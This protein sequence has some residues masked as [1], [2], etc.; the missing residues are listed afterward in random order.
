[1]KK[2][3]KIIFYPQ[4][5]R[6]LLECLP[7]INLLGEDDR[8][9]TNILIENETFMKKRNY[10]SSV[11]Y[12][13]SEKIKI[14]SKT[15]DIKLGSTLINFLECLFYKVFKKRANYLLNTLPLILI[16]F[17]LDTLDFLFA[18]ISAWFFYVINKPDILLIVRDRN[19][20]FQTSLIKSLKKKNKKVV[21]I[22]WGFFNINFLLRSRILSPRNIMGLKSNNYFHKL[23]ERKSPN[24]IFKYNNFKYSYYKIGRYLAAIFC[25]ICP[26]NPWVYGSDSSLC[27]VDNKETKLEL[28]KNNVKENK[29]IVCGNH[30]YDEIKKKKIKKNKIRQFLVRKYNLQNRIIVLAMPHVIEHNLICPKAYRKK[31]LQVKDILL[32]N[33]NK[34]ILLSVHPRAQKSDYEFLID[35]RTY[36]LEESLRNIIVGVDYLVCHWSGVTFWGPLVAK[37]TMVLDIF[38][39]PFVGV[40]YL[41]KKVMVVKNL[42]DLN[43]KIS[44]F[45]NMRGK[46]VPYEK[47]SV[48]KF[49]RNLFRLN[50]GYF[51][52]N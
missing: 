37:P 35:T 36:F 15:I 46:N 33:N 47:F 17:I 19:L 3:I 41:S 9:E 29:I 30:I 48:T 31:M 11:P 4:G 10:D 26:S 25:G 40:N 21:I 13:V 16:F 24:H 52:K 2:K 6:Y 14:I 39:L 44:Y 12:Q 34:S 38:S 49:K 43:K 50:N 45:Y 22:P 18:K 32:K 8:F 28:I 20:G 7:L 51:S 1:M 5:E 27:F 23:M 42:A